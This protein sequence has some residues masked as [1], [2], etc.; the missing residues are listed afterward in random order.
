M[1]NRFCIRLRSQ[2]HSRVEAIEE[3]Q[4]DRR[5]HDLAQVG[6]RFGTHQRLDALGTDLFV[7]L[8]QQ[9]A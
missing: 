2:R 5:H 6:M 4:I 8:M 9:R 1:P 3:T 7:G